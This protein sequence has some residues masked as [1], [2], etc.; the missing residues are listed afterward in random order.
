MMDLSNKE[1]E[2]IKKSKTFKDLVFLTYKFHPPKESEFSSL[3]ESFDSLNDLKNAKKQSSD[4]D[5]STGCESFMSFLDDLYY[6]RIHEKIKTICN[7]FILHKLD[8]TCFEKKCFWYSTI[9][10]TENKRNTWNAITNI[11]NIDRT[12]FIETYKSL[13]SESKKKD[14]IIEIEY[15][16]ENYNRTLIEIGEPDNAIEWYKDVISTTNFDLIKLLFFFH[17]FDVKKLS[18]NIHEI[19]TKDL[20]ENSDYAETLIKY[21]QYL[22]EIY[23]GV[24]NVIK[25]ANLK[26]NNLFTPTQPQSENLSETHSRLERSAE[27]YRVTE[28][29]IIKLKEIDPYYYKDLNIQNYETFINDTSKSLSDPNYKK[30]FLKIQSDIIKVINSSPKLIKYTYENPAF[31][32]GSDEYMLF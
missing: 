22:N 8:I 24:S 2:C 5:I 13:I 15:F 25:S 10:R 16:I 31:I 21:K 4:S 18:F 26:F 29:V 17:T 12:G 23:Y 14:F 32:F 6:K 30:D 1:K 27:D 9:C 11:N 28:Y 7:L 3:L 20:I 19:S